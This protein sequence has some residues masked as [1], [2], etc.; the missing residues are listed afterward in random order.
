MVVVA[1][2][3][4]QIHHQRRGKGRPAFD[5]R[6]WRHPYCPSL[7][8]TASL[9]LV[10]TRQAR[11]I[12]LASAKCPICSRKRRSYCQSRGDKLPQLKRGAESHSAL[13]P[14]FLIR[15]GD[16]ASVQNHEL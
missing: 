8:V 10:I 3:N 5:A 11:A 7:L 16:R 4:D 12:D 13:A 2:V 14:H 9:F 6:P 15:Y 1:C